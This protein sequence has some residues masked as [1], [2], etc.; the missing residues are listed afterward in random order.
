VRVKGRASARVLSCLVLSCVACTL[1]V[2]ENKT[3]NRGKENEETEQH[4]N[5]D[6]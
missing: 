3:K 1:G 6:L 4:S 5:N 2:G